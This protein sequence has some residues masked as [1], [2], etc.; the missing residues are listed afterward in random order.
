MSK[1][2][3]KRKRS[4]RLEFN[5]RLLVEIGIIVQGQV[6]LRTFQFGKGVDDKELTKHATLKSKGKV[7][8]K[9]YSAGGGAYSE[10]HGL[11]RSG[12]RPYYDGK[13][14]RKINRTVSR[15]ELNITGDMMRGLRPKQQVDGISLGK[16]GQGTTKKSGRNKVRCGFGNHAYKY[17][18]FTHKLRPWIG[19]SK[20]DRKAIQPLIAEVL[21]RNFYKR[22][23]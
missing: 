8:G 17:A 10:R 22:K 19:L 16:P 20:K 18:I 3:N 15:V 12:K 9:S 4:R 6:V 23:K 13:I 7:K 21:E 2:K 1:K 14:K 11:V 5:K